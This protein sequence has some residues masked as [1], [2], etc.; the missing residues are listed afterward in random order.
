VTFSSLILV[1]FLQ[2]H[3]K[4]ETKMS[5]SMESIE[6]LIEDNQDKLIELEEWIAT[7]KQ[8]PRSI[9]K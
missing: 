9:R 1:A 2:S 4:F 6:K 8:L 3:L 7:Q 5:E